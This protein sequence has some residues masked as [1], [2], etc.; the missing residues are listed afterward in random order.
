MAYTVFATEY[1]VYV[2]NVCWGGLYESKKS[3]IDE[4]TRFVI[5]YR[6]Y[7]NFPTLT[8]GGKTEN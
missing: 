5:Y 3:K 1:Y 2:Y 4:M 7:I 6:I 8:L